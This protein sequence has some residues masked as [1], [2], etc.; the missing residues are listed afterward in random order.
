MSIAKNIILLAYVALETLYKTI[1]GKYF[2]V[3]MERLQILM[4]VLLAAFLLVEFIRLDK[5]SKKN[6][7]IK[8]AF[9]FVY[10]AVRCLTFI[11]TGMQ[12]TVLR[13]I[14]FEGIYMLVLTELVVNSDFCKKIVMKFFIA[15]N[16]LLNIINVY[17]YWHSEAIAANGQYE[18]ALYNFIIKYTYAGDP[19]WCNYSSMYS[20]PNYMGMMTGI[21]LL[22]AATYLSKNM[23]LMKKIAAGVYFIFSLYCVWLSNSSA[24]Q[25]AMMAA[26]CA[27]A[28]VKYVK[29]F[30]PKRIT[31]ICLACSIVA[32]GLIYGF[33]AFQN[34]DYNTPA[35]DKLNQ[36]STQRYAIWK[37]SFYSHKEELMLGCGNITLEKRDRYQYNLDRGIDWGLD[38]K[39][40]LVDYVGPHNGYIGT[41]SCTGILGSIAFLLAFLKKIKDSSLL[42]EKHRFY[43]P[44]VF[45]FVVNLFECMII[46]NKNFYS[47]Y[48]FLILAMDDKTEANQ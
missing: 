33:I 44:M 47:L 30:T 45:I 46:V 19:Y 13:S 23:S 14:F 26:L 6:W 34:E 29:I 22:I 40:S 35:E 48:L 8:N 21:A 5:G 24:S 36:L 20:N 7:I 41:L 43:L 15:S 31:V 28:L 9:V 27:F 10:F 25:V 17:F 18:D 2:M 3:P 16:L 12:Y 1:F 42:G 38:V 11:S 32:T 39:G 4:A 37:D